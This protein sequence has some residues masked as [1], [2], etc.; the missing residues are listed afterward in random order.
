MNTDRRSIVH[1]YHVIKLQLDDTSYI[2]V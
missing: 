2:M 1:K